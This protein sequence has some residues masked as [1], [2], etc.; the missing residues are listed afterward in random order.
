MMYNIDR[1]DMMKKIGDLIEER[2]VDQ[3]SV[4]RYA[5][6]KEMQYYETSA[7]DGNNVDKAFRELAE[8]ILENKTDEEI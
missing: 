4:E 6:K 2:K 1:S 3:D 7:K 5:D 8:L